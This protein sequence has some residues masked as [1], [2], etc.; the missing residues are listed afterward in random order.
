MDPVHVLNVQHPASSLVVADHIV[1]DA[2][3]FSCNFGLSTT[4]VAR[5]SCLAADASSVDHMY[6]ALEPVM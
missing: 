2:W 4:E 6:F 1:Q 3:I 5:S